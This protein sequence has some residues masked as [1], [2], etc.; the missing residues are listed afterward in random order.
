M[1]GEEQNALVR[2]AAEL[3]RGPL[4]VKEL[5]TDDIAEPMQ[6]MLSRF[7]EHSDANQKKMPERGKLNFFL[8]EDEQSAIAAFALV[9]E[10]AIAMKASLEEDPKN[11]HLAR[12]LAALAGARTILEDEEVKIQTAEATKEK[13]ITQQIQLIL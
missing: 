9:G 12:S 13:L 2:D 1:S 3:A 11:E 6:Q 7:K 8:T 4:V 10:A 5:K